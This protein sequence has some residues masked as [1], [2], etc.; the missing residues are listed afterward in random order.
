MLLGDL[1]TLRQLRLPVKVVV[2]KSSS[3]GFIELEMKAAGILE[4]ATDLENPDF[5]KLA[6]AA[7]VLGLRAETPEQ[8]RPML[9]QALRHGTGRSHG[10]PAGTLDAANAHCGT[11]EGLQPLHDQSRAGWTRHQNS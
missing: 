10:Q 8:V 1:L 6:E 2:F 7:G 4:F 11:D 3:L 5:A 9:L